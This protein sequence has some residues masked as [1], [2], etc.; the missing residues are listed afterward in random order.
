MRRWGTDYCVKVLTECS[1]NL[2][3]FDLVGVFFC[4]G[5]LLLFWEGGFRIVRKP[6]EFFSRFRVNRKSNM[7]FAIL[8]PQSTKNQNLTVIFFMT[9]ENE[10][11]I[12]DI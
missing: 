5:F 11:Q 10:V 2:F 6:P 12:Q 1:P 9:K 3:W 8:A 7:S 4:L